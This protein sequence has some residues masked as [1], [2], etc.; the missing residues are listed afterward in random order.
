[1]KKSNKQI[2]IGIAGLAGSGKDTIA[3]YLLNRGYE[4]MSF[5]GTLK[6]CVSVVFGW[7]R[8]A[9]EGASKESREWR[10][11]ID[12]W[13]ANRLDIPHLTPRWIL[14][15]WGTEVCRKHFHDDIWIASL[16]NNMRKMKSNIVI[17]DCRFP[18]EFATIRN[19]GGYVG[20]VTRGK[21]PDWLD[22]AY[23]MNTTED[24]RIREQCRDELDKLKIHASE[25]S[26]IGLDYEFIIANNSS[27]DHLEHELDKIM[28]FINNQPTGLQLS[29]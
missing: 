8:E 19:L 2:I 28:N 7:D 20:R 27:L 17:T 26:S 25:Y 12:S 22:L 4:K 13:W 29:M 6:D 10:E 9:L 11:Q 1:M 3:S 5:A 14:Q 16:E 18:N 15:N 23:V 24:A 21:N